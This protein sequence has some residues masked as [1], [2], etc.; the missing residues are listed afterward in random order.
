MREFNPT[1]SGWQDIREQWVWPEIPC[2]CDGFLSRICRLG[3]EPRD[4]Q[5]AAPASATVFSESTIRTRTNIADGTRIGA[6]Y[7]PPRLRV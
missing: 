1:P 6:E 7:C 2:Y 5:K 3:L 4:T